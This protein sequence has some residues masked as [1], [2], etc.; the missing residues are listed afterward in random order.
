MVFYTALNLKIINLYNPHFKSEILLI[1]LA[2]Y[3]GKIIFE[4][5]PKIFDIKLDNLDNG[6]Y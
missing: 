5:W 2:G 3:F 1:F 4:E 6:Y